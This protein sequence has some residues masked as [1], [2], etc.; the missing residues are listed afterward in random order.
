MILQDF[1]IINR[2]NI[3]SDINLSL[4][5]EIQFE[6]A[7]TCGVGGSSNKLLLDFIVKPSNNLGAITLDDNNNETKRHTVLLN[8]FIKIDK[9]TIK[10]NSHLP[11]Q[12]Q[13]DIEIK[14]TASIE[15]SG[16]TKV[17][18]FK[19]TIIG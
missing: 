11:F 16:I 2:Q 4:N 13:Y 1:I 8:S 6:Y 15:G 18:Y 12:S 7:V 14:I 19:L 3:L 9:D 5:K 17:D 10:L